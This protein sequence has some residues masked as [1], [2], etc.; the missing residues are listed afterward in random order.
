MAARAKT[1]IVLLALFAGGC[2]SLLHHRE[3]RIIAYIF[4]NRADVSRID[5]R[6]LTHINYAFGLVNPEGTIYLKPEAPARIAELQALK[7]KNPRLKIL[8]SVGGWGADNFSDAALTDESRNR[9][10]ASAIDLATKYEFDGIDLD[11]EYPGQP[12]PGIKFRPEDRENFT[13]MLKTMRE[14]LDALSDQRKRRGND[15]YTLT[16]ASAAGKYFEHTEMDKLHVYLDWI[17]VMAYDMAGSWSKTT[18]HHTALYPSR[19]SAVTPPSTESYVKQHLASG[20]PRRKIVVG[21]AFYGRGWSGASGLY[22]PF[23]R[24]ESNFPFSR[25][26]RENLGIRHW[27][28]SARAPYIFDAASGLFVSYDDPESLREKAKFIRYHR[29]GGVMYWEHSHDPDEILLD[30]LYNNLE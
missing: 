20:I 7:V 2:S 19:A 24:S 5:A 1:L 30:A 12:G 22:Q 11:W 25:L 8:L 26:M 27:D 10:A 23:A 16:I 17:N 15:R 3:Y 21:V 29:L 28:R 6:K 4:G 13:L 9:F 18:G 14:H